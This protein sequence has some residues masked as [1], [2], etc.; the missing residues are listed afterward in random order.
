M[1]ID[2]LTT[3]IGMVAATCTTLSFVPQLIKIHRQGGR[4]LSTGMLLLYLLGVSLWFVYG[5]RIDAVEVIGANIVAG[6]LVFTALFMKLRS[7]KC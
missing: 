4:D 6:A 5:V 3:M 1:R 2:T 7:K